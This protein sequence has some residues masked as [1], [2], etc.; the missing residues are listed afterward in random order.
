M[1]PPASDKH[2]S[3]FAAFPVLC[4]AARCSHSMAKR[5]VYGKFLGA[6]A[7]IPLDGNRGEGVGENRYFK[8]DGLE[9]GFLRRQ[10]FHRRHPKS[11][12]LL[13]IY[14]LRLKQP[15]PQFRRRRPSRARA[16][17]ATSA[18]VEGSG[19]WIA[20]YVGL[21]TPVLAKTEPTPLDVNSSI[22]LLA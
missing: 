13:R 12:R 15:L 3:G 14:P 1:S 17:R 10:P 11:Q 6:E 16:P 2:P 4:P 7:L 18:K 5:P 22:V 21:S 19:I 9:A 8:W 20:I